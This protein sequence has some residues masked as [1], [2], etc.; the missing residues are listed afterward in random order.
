MMIVL[1]GGISEGSLP[2]PSSTFLDDR[3][4]QPPVLHSGS[5]EPLRVPVPSRYQ[6]ETGVPYVVAAWLVRGFSKRTRPCAN[7]DTTLPGACSPVPVG[8]TRGVRHRLD[9][10]PPRGSPGR[11]CVQPAR[12]WR[13]ALGV[14]GSPLRG[15]FC[16][17]FSADT[18]GGCLDRV[19]GFGVEVGT[20][21]LSWASGAA[22]E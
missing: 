10:S 5:P 2:S 11:F 15:R 12:L 14:P 1:W 20:R 21:G 8:V 19:H 9:V 6:L 17:Q 7:G 18:S 13:V 22:W 3:V 16:A 4:C